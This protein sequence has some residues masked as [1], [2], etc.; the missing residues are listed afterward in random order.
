MRFG[1]CTRRSSGF[2]LAGFEHVLEGAQGL[3]LEVWS[4]FIK[5]LWVYAWT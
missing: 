1:A 2:V 4:V 5:E 3:N